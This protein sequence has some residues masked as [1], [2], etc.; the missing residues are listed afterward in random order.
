[1][2]LKLILAVALIHQAAFSA[3]YYR[4]WRGYKRTNH[5]KMVAT[6]GVKTFVDD[7]TRPMSWA[8]FES[9]VNRWLIPATTSCCAE[10][11]LVAYLPALLAEGTK[12][13]GV[14]DEIALIVYRSEEAYKKTR[15]D[16]S[17]LEAQVYG[18]LHGDVFAI[19]DTKAE[20]L[21]DRER[22]SRSL[23]PVPFMGD[24]DLTP[25]EKN[26]FLPEAA[27]DVLDRNLDWQSGHTV[28]RVSLVNL[29]PDSVE[30]LNRYLREMKVAADAI[31]LEGY[32]TLITQH[33]V[34]E[35][36]NWADRRAWSEYLKSPV[37]RDFK[38]LTSKIVLETPAQPLQPDVAA[39]PLLYQTLKFGHAGN[40]RFQ[41]GKK[42]TPK[43]N[44]PRL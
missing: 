34:I 31:G 42:P 9:L 27:Y 3:P 1:M 11:S 44:H 8:D 16:K 40:I 18:P 13:N 41:P 6:D 30:R 36:M 33:Y 37:A 28:V 24:V 5:V 23:V 4:F 39:D 35:Y 43:A 32:T 20:N 7:P 12:E 26:F 17:N 14:H 38:N 10:S 25:N 22:T 21:E 29:T 19:G 2:K 15:E